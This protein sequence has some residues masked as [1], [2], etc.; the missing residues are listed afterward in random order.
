MGG[1]HKF[2]I[3]SQYQVYTQ[4]YMTKD[5]NRKMTDVSVNLKL[6]SHLF[7]FLHATSASSLCKCNSCL[8]PRRPGGTATLLYFNKSTYTCYVL[9]NIKMLCKHTVWKYFL[10]Y[11]LASITV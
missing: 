1:K 8:F 11:L 3:L 2:I 6:C 10:H 5:V 7:L 9:F 4:T